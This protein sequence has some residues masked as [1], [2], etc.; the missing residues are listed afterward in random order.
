MKT[1]VL[2]RHGKPNVPE[3]KTMKGKEIKKWIDSYNLS[4]IDRS[5]QP[6]GEAAEIA[7][8]CDVVVCSDLARSIESAKALEI[9]QINT[10]EPLF[11]EVGLP[12]GNV[13]FMKL[14]PE[15]WAV[16]FRILWLFGY[17][18]NGESIKDARIRAK[19]AANKLK[20]MAASNKSVLFVG[21]GFANRFIAKELLSSG[22]KGPK[23][24]GRSYWEFGIYEYAT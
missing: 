21:H 24:P 22:W 14:K 15:I 18:S 12:Y 13:P 9:K 19:N 10:I 23:S 4:G 1:I 16:L 20:E 2:L 5:C 8:G 17:S 7:K 3:Y 11:R 6:S